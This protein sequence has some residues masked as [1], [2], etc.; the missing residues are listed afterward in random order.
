MGYQHSGGNDNIIVK[1]ARKM[2]QNEQLI[3]QWA[4]A[5]LNMQLDNLLWQ[6]HNEINVGELWKMLCTYCYLP[7]LASFDVLQTCIQNGVNSEDYFAY[8]DSVVDGKYIALKYNQYVGFVDRSG[9]LVKQVAALK[10][11]AAE[12]Q[13][14]Q[15][16]QQS[17]FFHRMDRDRRPSIYRRCSPPSC[18]R[19]HRTDTL[20]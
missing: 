7:R 13:T 6:G 9:F 2:Q 8:A 1:A 20:P 12:V 17:Q 11:K 5:L 14:R 16:Q 19:N 10:Q 4:P 3:T 15:D 18:H